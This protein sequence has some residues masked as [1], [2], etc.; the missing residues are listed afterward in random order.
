MIQGF[1]DSACEHRSGDF[2]VELI[3]LRYFDS[4]HVKP[5]GR[6]DTERLNR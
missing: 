1:Y 4:P 3:F 6:D 2:V 5:E